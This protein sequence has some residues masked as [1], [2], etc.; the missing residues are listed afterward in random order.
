MLKTVAVLGLILGVTY[1]SL[2]CPHTAEPSGKDNF[3]KSSGS[4]SGC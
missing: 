2:F 1:G 4:V 3:S